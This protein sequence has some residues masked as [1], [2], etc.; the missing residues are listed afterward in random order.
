MHKQSTLK[1]F[2]PTRDLEFA[3]PDWLCG[4]V[5]QTR[6]S[7]ALDRAN[8]DAACNLLDDQDPHGRTWEIVRWSHWAVGWVD[9]IFTEPGSISAQV[10]AVAREH[11]TQYPSLD[12]ELWEEYAADDAAD[13]EADRAD[14]AVKESE[15]GAQDVADRDI[16]APMFDP[17]NDGVEG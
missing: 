8:F 9:E 4:P 3:K 13:E 15:G 7:Q 6:D 17:I 10:A 5:G 12:D 2:P 1:D 14:A 11:L 16:E